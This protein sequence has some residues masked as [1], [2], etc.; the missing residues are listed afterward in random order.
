MC[1]PNSNFSIISS[2]RAAQTLVLM[3]SLATARTAL[4]NPPEPDTVLYS[5]RIEASSEEEEFRI[6]LKARA[7]NTSWEITGHE[8]ALIRVLVD[9]RYDQ[10]VFLLQG[11]DEADYE[12]LIGPLSRGSHSLRLQ[13]DR[14]WAPEHPD[15][16]EVQR[17][18]VRR[19]DRSDPLEE[20]IL[21]APILH[22]RKDTVGRFSDVPL[23]LYWESEPRAQGRLL[24]YTIILSN[25]DGG[26]N[27]ERLMARWGR[28]SD[29]EWCYAYS[30]ASGK[31]EESYQARE[32]ETLP[33]RGVHDGWHPVLYDSTQN[34]N[35]ADAMADPA[36][37]RVR[38][39]PAE[40]K[41]SG[42]SREMMMDHYP[43]TYAIAA[44]EMDRE[45]KIEGVADPKTAKLSDQRNYAYLEVCARQSGTEL[46]FEIETRGRPRWFSSD[47]GDSR[48]RIGRS[49]CFRSTIELPA[50]TRGED[51]LRLRIDCAPAPV[52]EGE[53][54]VASPA[55]RLESVNLLFLLGSD[56]R[57]GPNLLEK[58]I[59]RRLTPPHSLTVEISR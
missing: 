47:H 32:H 41:L 56:Y 4:T 55:A 2:E 20:P 18:A 13:W 25:E 29:I 11:P 46:Y 45:G 15:A 38:M 24:T 51:L 59:N 52:P 17:V 58:K 39:V 8:C 44:K 43:W 6:T 31:V 50:G 3:L 57:P 26:T 35:F 42:H 49:G 33:F 34:N 9:D 12:F 10:H 37:V 21:R 16:P 54:P 28:T 23:L 19:I 53:R 36:P 7:R 48:S 14:S 22:I 5:T 27:T 1:G 30:R 40:A